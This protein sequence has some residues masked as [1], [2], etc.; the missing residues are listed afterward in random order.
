MPWQNFT[1]LEIAPTFNNYL[2]VTSRNAAFMLK[3]HPPGTCACMYLIAWLMFAGK[4]QPGATFLLDDFAF[5]LADDPWTGTP[6]APRHWPLASEWNGCIFSCRRQSERGLSVVEA[7]EFQD[8]RS[9]CTSKQMWM[10]AGG[11]NAHAEY[12]IYIAV[13][14]LWCVRTCAVSRYSNK[15]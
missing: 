14:I 13:S 6:T 11:K 9:G 2:G 4:V 1:T 3:S 5:F 12:I 10:Q 8:Q 7:T 15:F